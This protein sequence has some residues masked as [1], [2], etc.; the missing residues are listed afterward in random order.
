IIVAALVTSQQQSRLKLA[1]AL[2]VLGSVA[3]V[4]TFIALFL[5]GN[6]LIPV[7]QNVTL[8][9]P[10]LSMWYLDVVGSLLKYSLQI[11]AAFLFWRVYRASHDAVRTTQP[12][13]STASAMSLEQG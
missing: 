7:F 4:V 8:I 13:S 11:A 2:L 12:E 9:Y 5:T 10:P 3:N 1:V 6:L